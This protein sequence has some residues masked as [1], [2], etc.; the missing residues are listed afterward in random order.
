ML[1]CL[2]LTLSLAEGMENKLLMH[3]LFFHLIL[4]GNDRVGMVPVIQEEESGPT[5]SCCLS[6]VSHCSLWYSASLRSD[7]HC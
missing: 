2:H 4:K 1:Y 6:T 5:P 3:L 7:A